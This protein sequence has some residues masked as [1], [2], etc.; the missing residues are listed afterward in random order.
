MNRCADHLRGQAR[1]INQ[2]QYRPRPHG[3]ANE[4]QAVVASGVMLLQRKV[5]TPGHRR[6][7]NQQAVGVDAAEATIAGHH[8][9]DADQSQEN[10]PPAPHTHPV[11]ENKT[12]QQRAEQRSGLRQ[13]TGGA[14]ADT[15]LAKIDRDVMQA[16]GEK[17]EPEQQRHVADARQAD[18]FERCDEGHECRSYQKAQ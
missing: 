3:V 15:L 8:R 11:L 6:Q 13:H 17:A 2:Q 14:G 5:E 10:T 16:Y 4:G 9:D 1:Q 12:R 18:A 7:Q